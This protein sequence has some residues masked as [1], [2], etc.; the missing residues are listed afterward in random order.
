MQDLL[1]P[2]CPHPVVANDTSRDES[3][4]VSGGAANSEVAALSNINVITYLVKIFIIT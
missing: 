1:M 4:N 3:H 2:F